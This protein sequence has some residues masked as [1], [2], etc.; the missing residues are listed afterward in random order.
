MQRNASWWG[1]KGGGKGE[2]EFQQSERSETGQEGTVVG[3]G[4]ES[5]YAGIRIRLLMR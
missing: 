2:T 3:M 4:G 1:V 5:I